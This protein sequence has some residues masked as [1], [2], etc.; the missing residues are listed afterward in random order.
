MLFTL[1]GV[2]ES[3]GAVTPAP[4]VGQAVGALETQAFDVMVCDLTVETTHDG[5]DLL[6]KGCELQP[7]MAGIVLTSQATVTSAIAALQVGAVN[8]LV[9]P[10][11]VEELQL[12]VRA[13]V[14][15]ARSDGSR[16]GLQAARL[17]QRRAEERLT[18]VREQIGQ[19]VRAPLDALREEIKRLQDKTVR[20]ALSDDIRYNVQQV[21]LASAR[22]E[23]TLDTATRRE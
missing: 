5:L 14:E 6:A 3:E 4:T 22:L 16:E 23:A 7:R 1:A 15:Q 2:L 10:C 13:A 18:G 19:Q 8:Y 20:L 12:A 17:A 21:D 11:K 9:K